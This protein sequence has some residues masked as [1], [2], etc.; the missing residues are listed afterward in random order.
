MVLQQ[1]N[2]FVDSWNYGSFISVNAP[3]RT[4]STTGLWSTDLG[5]NYTNDVH[6]TSG[7]SFSAP[8]VSAL[9]ALI[10]SL[11]I[12]L[13]PDQ[14]KTI[15]ESTADKIDAQN[16]PYDNNGTGRNNYEGYGRI[17]AYQALLLTSA[18][19]NKSTLYRASG[20]NNQHTLERGHHG[21]LHEIF[22]SGGEIFYRRSSNNGSSWEIT[23]RISSGNGNNN[24][25]S[26]V[27]GS[28]PS[29]DN[30]RAV[31]QRKL[32]N[33]YYEIWYTYSTNSG[34]SWSIPSIVNGCSGVIVSYNQSNQNSGP[35]PSPVVGS[36]W[37]GGSEGNASFLLVYA[38]HSGLRYRYAV[39]SNNSWSIPAN[40]IVPWSHIFLCL[41][42]IF[43]N[44]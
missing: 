1:D 11:N 44:I 24:E 35:G 13:T 33:Y 16:H 32:D 26:I 29:Y 30:L 22:E 12:S 34:S 6:K 10:K 18:M 14:I 2:T 36:Y 43:G 23:K 5:G 9:A 17:N 38:D 3:G 40:D 27:A 37:R 21:H 19:L 7:T 28:D 39:E 25:V 15:L 31:W 41:V 42:S 8:Q 4:N 20:R